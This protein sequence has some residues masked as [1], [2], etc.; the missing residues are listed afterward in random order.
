[1]MDDQVL[2]P[3]CREDIAAV[4]AH[5]LGVA[6][7]VR[8]EFEIGSVEPGQLRQL[9]HGKHAVDQENLVI[10]SRKRLLHEGA[11]LLRHLGVDFEPDHR[12]AAAPL[13]RG[14]KQPHQIFRLFLDFEL[15]IADDAKGA[16]AVD[17]VA[18]KQP[19]DEQCG[20]LLE[21]NQSHHAIL[22]RGNADEA[23]DLAGHADQRI[24]RLAVGGA[25]Q[26]QRD[27]EAEARDK[28]EGMRRVDRK[29][30]Q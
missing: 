3:D 28:W 11:Q 30:R 21:R 20:R 2:L 24:H 23:V 26:M 19:A 7:N 25:R 29:R 9:V 22:A 12:S 17:G 18:G 8:H 5:A 13:Q 10:R 14:L 16:L 15:G 1:M 4:V 6:W 27:G